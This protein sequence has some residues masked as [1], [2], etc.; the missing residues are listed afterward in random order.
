MSSAMGWRKE[1]AKELLKPKR[2]RFRRRRVFSPNVD[3]I[4][5]MDL[6]DVHKYSALNKGYRYILVVLDIFSRYAWAYPLVNKTGKEVKKGLKHIFRA[7]GGRTPVRIWCDDGKEFF[8]TTVQSFLDKKGITLYS[9]FN[10]PKAAIAERFIRTLRRKMEMHYIVDQ[11]TVWY[12]VLQRLIDEYNSGYHRSIGMS[13]KQATQPKNCGKVFDELYSKTHKSTASGKNAR[14][15]LKVGDKVR[16]SVHKRNFEKGATANWS[17]EIFT[18][19]KVMGESIP[20]VYRIKDLMDENIEGGFYREQLEKTNQSIYR[21][22][23]VVKRRRRKNG[24]DESL[25]RWSGY[26]DKFDSW[27][28]SATVMQSRND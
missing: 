5:T 21:I 1:L 9:T 6:M 26:S 7:D 17:E 19:D 25:V 10:E 28:P 8:N 2:K 15:R 13:P 22:D 16:I 23:K 11:N 3:S 20:I 18:V 24:V 12:N 14:G 27:V 4:W